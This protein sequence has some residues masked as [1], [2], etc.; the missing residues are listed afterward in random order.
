MKESIYND[1]HVQDK[2]AAAIATS[3]H[4]EREKWHFRCGNDKSNTQPNKKSTWE[5]IKEF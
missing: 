3:A 4:L 1:G 2:G 5:I